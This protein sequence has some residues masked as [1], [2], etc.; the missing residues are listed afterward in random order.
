MGSK[1]GSAPGSG[2]AEEPGLASRVLLRPIP[3]EPYPHG[4]SRLSLLPRLSTCRRQRQPRRQDPHAPCALTAHPPACFLSC[5][6]YKAA[7]PKTSFLLKRTPTLP[8]Q[9]TFLA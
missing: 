8:L 6:S 4:S 2:D 7:L 5:Y 9:D 3:R 1:P